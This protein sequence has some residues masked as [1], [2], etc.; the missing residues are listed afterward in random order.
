MKS[1][2]KRNIILLIILVIWIIFI[3]LVN[4]ITN[5]SFNKSESKN[6]KDD[7]IEIK[8]VTEKVIVQG[9]IVIY[10]ISDVDNINKKN[11]VV[12][13]LNSNDVIIDEA[14][15]R[16]NRIIIDTSP[17]SEGE[18]KVKVVIGEDEMISEEKFSV[19]VVKS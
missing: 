5:Y 2:K 7:L 11:C 14:Y 15:I 16:E 9:D 18:Y 13:V 12:S 8:M 19:I 4:L 1:D 3:L 6:N 17:L 10:E